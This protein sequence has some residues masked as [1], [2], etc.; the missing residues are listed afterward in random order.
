MSS[1]GRQTNNKEFKIISP[2]T[3]P[4]INII[5]LINAFS[6]LVTKQLWQSKE[7]Y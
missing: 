7:Y 2:K 5:P 3:L 6:K 4:I 1:T